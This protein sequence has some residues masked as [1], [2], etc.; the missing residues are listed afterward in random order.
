MT[1]SL[2]IRDEAAKL[3]DA[4]WAFNDKLRLAED[5]GANPYGPFTTLI[6]KRSIGRTIPTFLRASTMAMARAARNT[7]TR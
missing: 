3:Y 6:G 7:P 2:E 1:P 4:A 5:S